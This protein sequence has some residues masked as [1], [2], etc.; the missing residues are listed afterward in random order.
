MKTLAHAH[1]QAGFTL[2]ETLVAV[3]LL[4]LVAAAAVPV[5]R[6]GVDAHARLTGLAA[7][8]EAHAALE[9]VLRGTL[10]AVVHAPGMAFSGESD[11]LSFA[12]QPAGSDRLLLVTIQPG[13]DAMT[14]QAAPLGGGPARTETIELSTRFAGF[15]FYGAPDGGRLEWLQSWPGPN[16]P[17]LVVLDLE[18]GRNGAVRRIEVAPGGRAALECDYDS[19][20]QACREGI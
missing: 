13:D 18:P 15:Y 11:S 19:G 3:A 6:G 17:R 12:S 8:R 5:L 10:E 7:E 20:L 14:I 2:T 9:R 16:P 4:A 1:A